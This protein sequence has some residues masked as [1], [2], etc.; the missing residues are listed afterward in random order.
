M[1][2]K[3]K[4]FDLNASNNGYQFAADVFEQFSQYMKNSDRIVYG[5]N[6]TGEITHPELAN[7]VGVINSIEW[8]DSCAY[9]DI[10]LLDTPQGKIYQTM[11]NSG[12][13]LDSVKLEPVWIYRKVGDKILDLNLQ[14]VN[15][16]VNCDK[17]D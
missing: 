8:A 15:V 17:N 14:Y 1:K 3:A 7:A 6:A 16:K 11:L 12:V 9:G 5:E 13:S 4:L 2:I 10:E